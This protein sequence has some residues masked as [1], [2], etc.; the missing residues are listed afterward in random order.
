LSG[1][2]WARG[3]WWA[4]LRSAKAGFWRVA[5]RSFESLGLGRSIDWDGYEGG[6][7]NGAAEKIAQTITERT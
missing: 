6:E 3:F 7:E 1:K 5:R 4:R 2:G